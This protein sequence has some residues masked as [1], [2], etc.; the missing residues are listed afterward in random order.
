MITIFIALS[1]RE[2]YYYRSL[3]GEVQFI[4]NHPRTGWTFANI[5]T[6][7]NTKYFLR[8]YL[9]Q[10]FTSIAMSAFVLIARRLSHNNQTADINLMEE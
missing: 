3:K 10:P 1:G 9:D 6:E 5:I 4:C 2:Y 7:Q 8:V